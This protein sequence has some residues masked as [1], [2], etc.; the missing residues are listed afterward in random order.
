MHRCRC[1]NSESYRSLEKTDNLCGICWAAG[2]S[3]FVYSS[4]HEYASIQG[5]GHTQSDDI[6]YHINKS[7]TLGN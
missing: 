4:D 5:S 3:E 1:C 2:K 7:S 6:S